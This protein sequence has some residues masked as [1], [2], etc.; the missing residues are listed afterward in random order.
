MKGLYRPHLFIFTHGLHFLV[1]YPAVFQ[2]R[3]VLHGDEGGEVTTTECF[4][5]SSVGLTHSGSTNRMK[6]SQLRCQNDSSVYYHCVSNNKSHSLGRN[7]KTYGRRDSEDE[8]DETS[9]KETSISM[10]MKCLVWTAP[11]EASDSGN[12]MVVSLEGCAGIHIK[13]GV[14]HVPPFPTCAA[15]DTQWSLTVTRGAVDSVSS[16]NIK[17]AFGHSFEIKL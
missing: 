11:V 7:H 3:P 9:D 16:V 14:W 1:M 4:T 8:N 15:E 10:S 6:A 12:I 13:R 17:N 5:F 2:G